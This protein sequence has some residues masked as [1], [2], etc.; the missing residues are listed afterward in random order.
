MRVWVLTTSFDP[1]G[2]IAVAYN[3][4]KPTFAHTIENT[5]GY[6]SGEPVSMCCPGGY[7][8]NRKRRMT[9]TK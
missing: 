7:L 6:K 8:G 2:Y 4:N 5:A 1:A 9:I 3:G